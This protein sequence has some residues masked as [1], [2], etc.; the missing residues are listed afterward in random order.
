[1]ET[2]T[3]QDM[4]QRAKREEDW[5][6]DLPPCPTEGLVDSEVGRTALDNM[7]TEAK[8]VAGVQRLNEARRRH[9]SKE[10]STLR[11]DVA[12]IVKCEE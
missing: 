2:R 11:K 6:R 8:R 1:M 9:E 7:V 12:T 4:R 3:Q 10:Q 5:A